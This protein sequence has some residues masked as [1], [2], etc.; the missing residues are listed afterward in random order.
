MSLELLPTSALSFCPLWTAQCLH[1]TWPVEVTKMMSYW[2]FDCLNRMQVMCVR[3]T[4]RL[5]NVFVFVA[6]GEDWCEK[7]VTGHILFLQVN[8]LENVMMERDVPLSH[9]GCCGVLFVPV[10]FHLSLIMLLFH[11]LYL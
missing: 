1:F 3:K 2:L 9:A 8:K 5:L 7:A 4:G 6:A 10:L 11:H